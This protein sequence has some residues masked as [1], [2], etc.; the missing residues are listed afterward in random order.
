MSEVVLV[1]QLQYEKGEATFHAAGGL[2]IEPVDAEED[3]LAEAIRS[4]RARAVIVGVNH[5]RGPLYEAL[6]E[7]AAGRGA[8]IARFGVGHDG[9]DKTL[10]ARH[11]IVVTNTPGVLEFSV[12]ELTM[13]LLGSLARHLGAAQTCIHSGRTFCPPGVEVHGKTLLIVG[14]G[15]IGRRVARMA[16]LGFGMRVIAAGRVNPAALEQREGRPL[17]RI[18]ADSGL[19]LYT[20]CLETA[21]CQAD[22]VS[23][24]VPAT[25]QTDR[26]IDLAH[27]R[28]MKR[29]AL[30][31]NMARGS[32][33]DE[34]ALYDSLADG[35][36]A[37]A[38]L[39]V[40]QTEPYQPVQPDKDLRTLD[41]VVLTPHI[42]SNTEE[43][44]RRIVQTCLR[45]ITEFLAGRRENLSRVGL[46]G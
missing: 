12:A 24:H 21:L 9:I 2:K 42:G 44:N 10:A 7:V 5:Y 4:R 15:T 38:A 46:P 19:S 45:N 18:L 22:V 32:V 33:I 29:G 3:R 20:D 34:A 8:I 11:G 39:D 40:L 27:I 16:G 28:Q 25:P 23:L 1:T 43:A 14:L 17:A 31:I 36:L 30:L 35:H 13:W 37:G 6:G 41:N 26:M